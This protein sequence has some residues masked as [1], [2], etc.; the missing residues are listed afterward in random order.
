MAGEKNTNGFCCGSGHVPGY[1][2]LTMA[3]AKLAIDRLEPAKSEDTVGPSA[4][5]GSLSR[6]VPSTPWK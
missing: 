6:R 1:E 2:P 3:E 5:V 4:V